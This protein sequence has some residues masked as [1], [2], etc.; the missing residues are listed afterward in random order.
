M[1]KILCLL[2]LICFYGNNIF[3]QTTQPQTFVSRDNNQ[4]QKVMFT[5]DNNGKATS[6]SYQGAKD[7][8]FV[9]LNIIKED[10]AEMKLITERTD[11]KQKIVWTSM[12]MM[13]GSMFLENGETLSFLPEKTCQAPTGEQI[14]TSGAPTFL[15]FYYAPNA[16][17]AFILLDIPQGQ[18]NDTKRTKANEMYYEI[19]V[20]NKKGK[21]KLII[22]NDDGSNKAKLKLVDANQK[23]TLFQ[24]KQ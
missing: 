18:V 10:E 5:F 2:L 8:K 6:C 15:P 16:K 11:N 3:A 14:I 19:K 24:E 4:V 12:W 7:K 21:C 9:E 22:M 20:P 23:S 17:S 1:K 13:S